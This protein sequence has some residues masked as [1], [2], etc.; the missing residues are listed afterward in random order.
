VSFERVQ[1]VHASRLPERHRAGDNRRAHNR[2]ERKRGNH[3]IDGD[4]VEPR[5]IVGS[6]GHHRGDHRPGEGEAKHAAGDRQQQDLGNPQRP[7]APRVAPSAAR[8]ASSYLR[9]ATRVS[10]RPDTLAHAI[11]SRTPTAIHNTRSAGRTGPNTWSRK[12]VTRVRSPHSR[13]PSTSRS[14]RAS[15]LS[16]C[17]ASLSIG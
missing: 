6:E 1:R 12:G 4:L 17:D 9:R 7:I 2:S 11:R 5:K 15:M 10:I 13:R 14:R 8:T 16:I 3:R